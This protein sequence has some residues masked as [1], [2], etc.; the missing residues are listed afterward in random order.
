M[1]DYAKCVYV[2]MMRKPSVKA[3]VERFCASVYGYSL[4]DVLAGP[5]YLLDALR[6]RYPEYSPVMELAQD[7]SVER[8]AGPRKWKEVPVEEY[9]PSGRGARGRG[10]VGLIAL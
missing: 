6:K 5:N 1:I 10:V 9:I 3:G 8:V 4:E 2:P 7:N